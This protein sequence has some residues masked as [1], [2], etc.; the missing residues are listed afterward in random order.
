VQ[1]A[2]A[3]VALNIPLY[4]FIRDKRVGECDL[5]VPL[6]K[7]RRLATVGEL[8]K[9]RTCIP[10]GSCRCHVCIVLTEIKNDFRLNFVTKIK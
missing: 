3:I 8:Q 6:L 5:E 9:H 10:N 1:T 2:K 7:N 4:V